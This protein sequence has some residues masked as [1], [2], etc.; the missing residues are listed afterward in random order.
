MILE[1]VIKGKEKNLRL[2]LDTLRNE[3]N[4]KRLKFN[5]N[6]KDWSYLTILS[7]AEEKVQ[8]ILDYIKEMESLS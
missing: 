2:L 7:T 5:D 1:E 4:H 3:L 6:K 8:E